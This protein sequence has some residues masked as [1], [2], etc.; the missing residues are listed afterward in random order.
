MLIP[1]LQLPNCYCI[2]KCPF[3]MSIPPHF[4]DSGKMTCVKKAFLYAITIWQLHIQNQHDS[5]SIIQRINVDF[6]AIK[7]MAI[8]P[9]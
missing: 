8:M 9:S 5:F 2:R 6:Y 1:N 7:E 4:L 3:G